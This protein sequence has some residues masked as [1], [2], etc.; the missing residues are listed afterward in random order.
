MQSAKHSLLRSV[1]LRRRLTRSSDTRK[2][3]DPF[4][5]YMRNDRA[6]LLRCAPS[7]GFASLGPW[8]TAYR[9][10]PH[11]PFSIAPILPAS[12]KCQRLPVCDIITKD[13]AAAGEHA[14][15]LGENAAAGA[16]LHFERDG[17]QEPCIQLG[18]NAPPLHVYS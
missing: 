8:R 10:L 14:S 16:D 6:C 9:L 7:F 11:F 5:I 2:L 15:I 13:F 1:P 18:G 12:L 17:M 3:V 4:G